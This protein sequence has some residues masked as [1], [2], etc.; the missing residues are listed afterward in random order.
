MTTEPEIA[1]SHAA[2]TSQR[3]A[4]RILRGAV[5]AHD[6]LFHALTAVSVV[7]VV[8]L[9]LVTLR[10]VVGRFLFNDPSG[11]VNEVSGYLVAGITF[12]GAGYALRS[13]QMIA[14]TLMV[15]RVPQRVRRW[16]TG[17]GLL[18]SF[19]VLLVA[20]YYAFDWVIGNYQADRRS[21]TRLR[22]RVWIPQAVMLIGLVGLQIELLRHALGCLVRT[23]TER[24][25]G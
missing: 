3:T 17:L 15:D 4:S 2:P 25:D 7:M 8:V 13:G 22:T 14:V 6:M 12:L 5:R 24:H 9:L 20:V 18:F 1:A 19:L 21:N 16:L 10:E 23:R 11:W